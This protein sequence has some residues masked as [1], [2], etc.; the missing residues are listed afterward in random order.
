MTSGLK[1]PIAVALLLGGLGWLLSSPASGNAG[2]KPRRD[3]KPT[4]AIS[5]WSMSQAARR[6]RVVYET[7]CIG[8]HG[9]EGNGDGVAAARL[10]P[11]PRNFQ[12]GYYKFRSTPSGELPTRED[13][14]RTV[15]CGLVG[16]SMPEFK[17]LAEGH[18]RDVV[19]YVL[20]L[21]GYGL[22]KK[23]VSFLVD[24]EDLDMETIKKDHLAAIR[25]KVDLKINGVH[26]VAVSP[27]PAPTEEGIAQGKAR[28]MTQCA[29]CHGI[30]GRGDGP[31]SYTLRDWENAEIRPRDFTTGVFRAG[32]TS[33]DIFLRLRTG[34]NGT[35]MPATDG[36]DAE[37][38][39]M[40]HF[41]QSMKVATVFPTDRQG[42]Q[43]EGGHR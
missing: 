14:L 1:V 34:L 20:F 22:A 32:S 6:G 17:L 21:T 9:E 31:S 24:S 13:L 27:E 26:P 11:V 18:R 8:C 43:H 28:Y 42:C 19:E 15:T 36:E 25:A 35:P 41:I 39:N 7:W 16:S 40:V 29:S 4:L 38:W 12:K 5:D 23:E 30:T 2:A 33:R 10:N 37:L 3:A